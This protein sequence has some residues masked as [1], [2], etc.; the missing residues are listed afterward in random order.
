MSPWKPWQKE[1]PNI[2]KT[3]QVTWIFVGQVW[4]YLKFWRFSNLKILLSFWDLK[5][6]FCMWSQYVHRFN[7]KLQHVVSVNSFI[8]SPPK[9]FYL[10]QMPN[11]RGSKCWFLNKVPNIERAISRWNNDQFSKLRTILRSEFCGHRK[12]NQNIYPRCFGGREIAKNK[13]SKVLVDTL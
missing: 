9:L 7:S 2:L 4:R 8:D 6:N 1:E 3:K 11:L 10:F 12:N 13:V 5:L